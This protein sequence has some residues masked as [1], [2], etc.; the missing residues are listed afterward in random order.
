MRH[1]DAT[2]LYEEVHLV[3]KLL[4]PILRRIVHSLVLQ[5]K[6][7]EAAFWSTI[8]TLSGLS[9]YL[10]GQVRTEAG[11]FMRLTDCQ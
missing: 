4:L 9:E 2:N 5:V 1:F 7:S 6:H 11:V 8:R 10:D 3:E